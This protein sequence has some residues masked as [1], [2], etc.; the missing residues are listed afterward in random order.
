MVATTKFRR[1]P[2]RQCHPSAQA[3][4]WP[5]IACYRCNLARLLERG[6][7]YSGARNRGKKENILVLV[8]LKRY[9]KSSRKKNENCSKIG[10]RV[11]FSFFFGY[12][13]VLG[14]EDKTNL[15]PIFVCFGL[16]ARKPLSSRRA[17]SL[18]YRSWFLM[19]R[20]INF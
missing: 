10:F 18:I 19:H 1:V 9:E 4:L 5:R 12:F 17:G 2:H 20:L 3:L 7:R 8:S 16:E 14:A 11:A 13:F 15:F 6:F